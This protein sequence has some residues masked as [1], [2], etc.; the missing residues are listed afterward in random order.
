MFL[1]WY[2]CYSGVEGCCLGGSKLKTQD[3]S[4]HHKMPPSSGSKCFCQ[5]ISAIGDRRAFVKRLA[6]AHG[7]GVCTTSSV[8]HGGLLGKRKGGAGVPFQSI[9][10]RGTFTGH[11]LC[12]K[13]DFWNWAQIGPLMKSNY[14]LP[15][16]WSS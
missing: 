13:I 12:S 14:C 6:L 7:G 9:G 8:G 11:D 15:R 3:I 4:R 5:L 16:L 10:P 1:V 2:P